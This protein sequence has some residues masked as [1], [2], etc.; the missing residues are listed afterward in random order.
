MII[1]D[2]ETNVFLSIA[3]VWEIAIKV[4]TGKLLLSPP[5]D[6]SNRKTFGG[7]VIALLDITVDHTVATDDDCLSTIAIRLIAS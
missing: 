7:N 4:G 5:F 1:E 3:S 2:A 6:E